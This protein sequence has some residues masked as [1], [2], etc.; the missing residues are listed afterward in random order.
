MKREG[1]YIGR[2]T[3]EMLDAYNLKLSKAKGQIIPPQK[4][5]PGMKGY[6]PG[7]EAYFRLRIN[8]LEGFDLNTYTPQN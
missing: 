8:G 5:L 7:L 1:L 3:P 4:K 2:G 6:A